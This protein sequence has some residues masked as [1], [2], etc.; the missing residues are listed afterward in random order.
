MNKRICL[1]ITFFLSLNCNVYSQEGMPLELTPA[2]AQNLPTVSLRT[3]LKSIGAPLIAAI[4]FLKMPNPDPD[5][6]LEKIFPSAKNNI[7]HWSSIL[8][9]PPLAFLIKVMQQLNIQFNE[10]LF[11]VLQ[12]QALYFLKPEWEKEV[13][14]YN[15]IRGVILDK[16]DVTNEYHWAAAGI[17][18]TT[19][20]V[21]S[22]YLA[23]QLYQL[24]HRLGTNTTKRT[25]HIYP[26]NGRRNNTTL[27]A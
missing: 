11:P 14:S 25:T 26:K 12:D 2:I 16:F 17:A 8:I 10:K 19:G 22:C 9:K 7:Q 23:Y 18:T 20:A 15:G 21:I 6:F 5:S 1:I 27:T 13:N 4:T 24:T 3:A